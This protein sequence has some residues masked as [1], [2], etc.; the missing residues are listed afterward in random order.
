MPEVLITGVGVV[1]PIGIGVDAVAESL[2]ER[3]TGIDRIAELA[4]VG[5]IA[6]F[7]GRV[8]DFDPKKYVQPRK[9][10]KV[11][12]REIQL[13]FAAGELAWADSGLEDT[14]V[15][16]ERVGVV[17]GAGLLYCDLEELAA[18]LAESL[19]AQG[20]VDLVEWGERGL[21]QLFPLWMLKYLPNMAACHVGIRRQA[22]GP[23][24]TISLG[25]VSSLLAVGEAAA[26]I[27]RGAADVMLAGGTS[28]KL[29]LTDLLFHGGAGL[30]RR[31]D[32]PR[33]ACRP[34]DAERDGA[35]AGE[36]AAYFVL[37]SREHAERRGLGVRGG[38]AWGRVASVATRFE[39]SVAS[40]RP[41]GKSIA[42][43]AAAA[44]DAA[45]VGADR[46]AFVKAHGSS[47][48]ESDAVE[49]QAIARVVGDRPV[50]APTSYVGSSGA[51]GGAVE[52]AL[53]LVAWR[54]GLVPATLNY[55]TADPDCPLNV[56]AEHRDAEG[57]SILALNYALTGQSVAAVIAAEDGPRRAPSGGG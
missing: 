28:T 25:D 48:R 13:A 41:T 24:N 22:F 37:E 52:L 10:L 7:G 44:L 32:D 46:L 18:P 49:A 40:R 16:P 15:D 38:A 43:A 50:T 19:N 20:E 42:A 57:S 27:E 35:V 30:S 55:T 45:G 2:R 34:F 56:A 12:A 9:S 47:R 21:R 6:P 31:A 36:G 23:T 33:G 14:S 1:S 17:G 53:A 8:T 11:M 26:A 39:D 4:E 5:W 3:R 54:D 29:D 51:A